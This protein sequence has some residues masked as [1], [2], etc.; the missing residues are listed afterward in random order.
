MNCCGSW[1]AA[2]QSTA[3]AHACM[4]LTELEAVLASYTS[5]INLMSLILL[6]YYWDVIEPC[7][8]LEEEMSTSD[9]QQYI[10]PSFESTTPF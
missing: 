1:I 6:H 8:T 2:A 3:Y 9:T 5:Y 7:E 10:F 4:C